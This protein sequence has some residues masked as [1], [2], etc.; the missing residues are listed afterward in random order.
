MYLKRYHD[1]EVSNSGVWQILKRLDL[2]PL[3]TSNTPW[4]GAFWAARCGPPRHR[5][6][7]HFPVTPP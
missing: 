5:T 1:V 6:Q 7:R 4:G 2:N 3:P